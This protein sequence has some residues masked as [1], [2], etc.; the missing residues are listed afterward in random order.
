M[1]ATSHQNQCRRTGTHLRQAVARRFGSG[2]FG[3]PVKPEIVNRTPIAFVVLLPHGEI[4]TKRAWRQ[5]SGGLSAADLL[6]LALKETIMDEAL[7]KN[8]RSHDIEKINR[9][10][11][12]LFGCVPE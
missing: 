7:P 8:T 2:G 10:R 12:Q 9:L 6:C 3:R 5:Q 11:L 4:K 1:T